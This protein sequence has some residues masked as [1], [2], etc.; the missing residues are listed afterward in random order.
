MQTK[1]NELYKFYEDRPHFPFP[2]NL[3]SFAKFEAFNNSWKGDK[4]D[5]RAYNLALLYSAD[6]YKE[7]K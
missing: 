3:I 7:L 2:E 6:A 5:T 4:S 1:Y